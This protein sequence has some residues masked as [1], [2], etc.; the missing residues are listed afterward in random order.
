MK[1][2]I[3]E[4][5]LFKDSSPKIVLIYDKMRFELEEVDYEKHAEFYWFAREFPRYFRYHFDNIEYRLTKVHNLYSLHLEEF[6]N[7]YDEKRNEN[8]HHMAISNSYTFQIYWE[9]EALLNAISA[10][11]DI[12]AR[13]SGLEFIEQT[14]VSLNNLAKKKDLFGVVEIL[15]NAKLDWIDEISTVRFISQINSTD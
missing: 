10:A 11:L 1:I 15:R 7:E 2:K 3:S 12:L 9:F 14:P 6:K 8:C 4:I 5:P 13:I